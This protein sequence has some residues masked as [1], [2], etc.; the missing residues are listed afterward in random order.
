MSIGFRKELLDGIKGIVWVLLVVV[1]FLIVD[2]LNTIDSKL[3][4][5]DNIEPRL[6]RIEYELKLK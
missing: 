2:K 1:G 6:I 5:L 4:K 3:E